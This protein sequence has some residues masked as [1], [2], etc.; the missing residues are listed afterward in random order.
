MFVLYESHFVLESLSL[1][2]LFHEMGATVRADAESIGVG[3]LPTS[4]TEH[5]CTRL[6]GGSRVRVVVMGSLTRGY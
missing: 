4:S 5:S 2:C 1:G 3:R 6:N